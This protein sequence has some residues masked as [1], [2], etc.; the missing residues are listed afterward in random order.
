MGPLEIPNRIVMPPMLVGYAGPRG[1][2]TERLLAYYE[3]RAGGGAGLV[4]VEASYVRKDGKIL[5]GGL[6][7]HDDELVPGLAKLADVIKV[8]GARAAIQVAHGGIQAHVPQP[9][10]PSAIGRRYAPPPRTPRELTT[11]EVEELVEAFVKAAERAKAA[12]FDLVEVHGTHGYIVTQF[13]SPLTNKRADRYGADRALF[14]IEVVQRIKERCGRWFPVIFRFCADEFVEGGITLEYSKQVAKRLVEEA[15]V[16]AFNVTG[17]NYDVMDLMSP[18]YLHAVEEGWFFRLAR[19]IKSV[20]GVPIISGGLLTDPAVAEEAVAKG[21][22]DAVFVGRQ[23]I[24]DPEWPRKV[25]EGRVK[26]VRPCLA[27]LDGCLGR[28]ALGRP[29]WC[30]VNALTGLEWR[31]PSE[32]S[33]PKALVK[34][35]VLV[36]GGG[37]GGLEASR[38]AALRGHEV[39]LVDSGEALGGTLR[40]AS[41]PPFKKRLERLLRWYEGQLR[42][43]GVEVVLK[44]VATP[45]WLREVRPDAVIVATGSRPLIPRIPGVEGAVTADDALTGRAKVGRR[46]AVI[47]GGLVGVE[48]ALHFAMEGRSVTVLEALPE[49][50]RDLAPGARFAL[51]RPGGL[52]E[53]Y[54]V[55]VLTSVTVVGIG[56]GGVEAVRPPLER[57]LIEADTVVLAVGRQSN[58]DPELLKAA[59]EAAKEV[60]IVGDAKE[61]RK[62]LDAIHEGFFAAVKI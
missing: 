8:H 25:R 26:D 48:T 32:G 3:A 43:L 34:K 42:E 13:L 18:P 52:L 35:R 27:C 41:I 57:L 16:D 20:V 59:K 61:P 4:I 12:G 1:E 49:V 46:I 30:T 37:P 54:G 50:A 40:V 38:V 23:L 22:V 36:I 10:G 47:G 24:A 29:V 56:G 6:G 60:Y 33:V 58:L 62:M 45:E 44:T 5:P 14:A 9:V 7:I 21:W 15:G 39:T 17:G 2:V 11:K 31:W 28:L 53:R 51:L 55:R 19:E